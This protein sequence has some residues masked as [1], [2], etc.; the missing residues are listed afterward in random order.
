VVPDVLRGQFEELDELLLFDI[1][2]GQ[3]FLDLPLAEASIASPHLFRCQAPNRHAEQV[4]IVTSKTLV[5]FLHAGL[6]LNIRLLALWEWPELEVAQLRHNVDFFL[7]RHD[8]LSGNDHLN[9]ASLVGQ[10]LELLV[11]LVGEMLLRESATA[12]TED[13]LLT[14]LNP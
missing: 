13:R 7:V 8:Q 1:T 10:L 14:F 9:E 2:L 3:Q 4:V 5:V 12:K 11:E 6:S